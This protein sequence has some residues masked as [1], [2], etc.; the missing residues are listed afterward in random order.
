MIDSAP[1]RST[2]ALDRDSG[3]TYIEVMVTI[4]VGVV[5]MLAATTLASTGAANHGWVVN[6]S[7]VYD[8]ARAAIDRVAADLRNANAPAMLVETAADGNHRV[9]LRTA[10]GG[11]NGNVQWGAQARGIGTTNAERSQSG[12]SVRYTVQSKTDSDGTTER[13]LVRQILDASSDVVD[14]ERLARGLR[15]G[16][17]AAPGF[18]VVAIGKIWRVSL[19]LHRGRD[20]DK[21]TEFTID[22]FPWNSDS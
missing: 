17:A 20:W 1:R 10:V 22:V 16:V 7:K 18:S 12:Y 2:A 8:D 19:A 6:Q 3:F 21:D 14:E 13:T 11:T 15:G 5:V 9:T 4:A